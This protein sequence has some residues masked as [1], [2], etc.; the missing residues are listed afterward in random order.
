[1][2]KGIVNKTLTK[3]QHRPPTLQGKKQSHHQDLGA[4]LLI[5]RWEDYLLALWQLNVDLFL[6]LH[7][8]YN[9]LFP[10][11]NFFLG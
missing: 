8:L 1:M 3:F 11:V 9:L 10:L 2:L 4:L 5:L 7:M 6:R